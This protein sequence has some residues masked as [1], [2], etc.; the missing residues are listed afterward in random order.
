MKTKYFYLL[1]VAGILLFA[2]QKEVSQDTTSPTS[3]A[4]NDSTVLSK[5]IELDTLNGRI[6]TTGVSTFEYDNLKRIT[7]VTT[8]NYFNNIPDLTGNYDKLIYYYNGVDTF[9][10]KTLYV[11]F[12]KN[13]RDSTINFFTRNA[14]QIVIRDSSID[15]FEDR[16]F[17]DTIAITSRYTIYADSV[18]EDQ[19][20]YNPLASTGS[21][22]TKFKHQLIRA[23]NHITKQVSSDYRVTAYGELFNSNFQFDDKFNPFRKLDI[24]YPIALNADTEFYNLFEKNN[25][26]QSTITDQYNQ[27]FSE[28]RNYIYNNINYPK[29]AVIYDPLQPGKVRKAIFIYTK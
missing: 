10:Y 23:N 29:T 12:D 25:L 5:Y 6:D 3:S 4:G 20:Y 17:F 27:I 11:Y 8:I 21:N 2:C 18:I 13:L 1:L 24:N 22:Y 26:L 14:N 16:S 9:P 28:T 15:F 19:N 7:K